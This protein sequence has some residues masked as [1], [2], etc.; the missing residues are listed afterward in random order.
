MDKQIIYIIASAFSTALIGLMSYLFLSQIK[1]IDEVRSDLKGHLNTYN[2]DSKE[3]TSLFSRLE[4]SF[5]S[6]HE[7]NQNT[8]A[9]FNQAI[10]RLQE[11]IDNTAQ[12]LMTL[13]GRQLERDRPIGPGQKR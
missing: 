3:Y 6:K 5:E 12:Q 13:M 2:K 1:K 7:E 9:A 8:I 4:E 11:K 10:L